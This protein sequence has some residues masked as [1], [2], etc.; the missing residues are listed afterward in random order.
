[1]RLALVTIGCGCAL[2]AGRVAQ[3]AV[4]DL[5]YRYAA[6]CPGAGIAKRVDRWLMY[7]CNCT[8][9][10]AWAL[11]ANGQRVDWFV[12][13][14]MDARN[15]PRV[16]RLRGIPT[17]RV[18]RVGAVAVWPTLSKFGHVGYVTH[19]EPH[20][21]FDVAE[22]NLPVDGVGTFAFDVRTDVSTRGVLF[23]YVPRRAG[24]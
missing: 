18:P 22:Y 2:V 24:S 12:P 20:G 11:A 14:A 19:V 6:D 1:V 7:E 15:W 8:S 16:A 3:A 17:G 9:Y 23:V 13:G 21:E 10:V 5:G 4:I